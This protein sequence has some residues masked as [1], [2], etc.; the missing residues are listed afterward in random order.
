ME[1]HHRDV[2]ETCPRLVR[3]WC[4]EAIV[5]EATLLLAV[6]DAGLVRTADGDYLPD[7]AGV[8]EFVDDLLL[9]ESRDAGVAAVE[10]RDRDAA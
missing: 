5:A 1:P 6:D 10:R 8:G 4:H 9:A 3:R 2:S 7:A